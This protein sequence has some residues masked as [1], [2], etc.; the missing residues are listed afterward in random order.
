MK[1]FITRFVGGPL[2]GNDVR[3]PDDA[4]WP[5]TERIVAFHTFVAGWV[6][7]Q[8]RADALVIVEEFVRD[9]PD[10]DNPP[11]LYERQRM[12]TTPDKVYEKV[13]VPIIRGAEYEYVGQYEVTP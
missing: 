6:P 11:A 4:P 8:D 10:P 7:V 3:W 13:D 12:S 1:G 5:P 2:D 9:D